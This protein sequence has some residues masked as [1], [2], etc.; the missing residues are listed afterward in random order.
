[1]FGAEQLASAAEEAGVSIG[2][3]V[4]LDVGLHRVGIRPG[5]PLLEL[6]KKVH[7]STGLR[8][9]GF[10]F[11][12]GHIK[13]DAAEDAPLRAVQADITEAKALVE[14]AG[15][16]VGIV[17][18]GSTPTLF[19]SHQIS[20]M[21][22]IRPGT[23]IFND[24]NTWMGGACT[25]SE[26][27]ASIIATVVSSAVAGQV[28][29]DAGSKTL[30]SDRCAVPGAEGFGYFPDSP[31]AILQKMNEEHGYVD[32]QNSETEW[33]LGEKVRLIPNHICVAVNLHEQIYGVREGRVVETWKVEG[34]GKLQ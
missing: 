30:S 22:E 7:S 27:A 10:N 28:I 25:L 4:E 9:L 20:G 19:E 31:S 1:M 33:S 18:G 21:N 17:S 3:L 23:Y 6:V 14:S 26:C 15:I 13:L 5:L 2:V 12:P 11:Y 29:I 32:V 16:E 24:R 8:F 34:R